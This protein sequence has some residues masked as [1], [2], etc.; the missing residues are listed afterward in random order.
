M[1]LNF[2]KNV[3][4]FQWKFHQGRYLKLL[5]PYVEDLDV[6]KGLPFG[7]SQ[8]DTFLSVLSDHLGAPVFV[9][10]TETW[11]I[12]G[13]SRAGVEVRGWKEKKHLEVC[14]NFH[15]SLHF[16]KKVYYLGLGRRK[17]N[18]SGIKFA[19]RPRILRLRRRDVIRKV[20]RGTC[21]NMG[22]RKLHL[23]QIT[24]FKI[25]PDR[26]SFLDLNQIEKLSNNNWQESGIV[27]F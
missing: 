23:E 6:V 2:G 27:A 9:L 5:A 15:F 12:G 10:K 13:S 14:S 21:H 8:C 18:L 22:R 11:S 7:Q 1:Y 3:I 25:G 19:R 17:W 16:R 4:F 24:L 26:I 20:F